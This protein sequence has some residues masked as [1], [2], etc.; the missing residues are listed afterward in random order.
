[1]KGSRQ[2]SV[3]VGGGGGGGKGGLYSAFFASIYFNT[4]PSHL[5][6]F[7]IPGQG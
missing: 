1:M 5:K 3:C 7:S 4:I 2:T 6:I